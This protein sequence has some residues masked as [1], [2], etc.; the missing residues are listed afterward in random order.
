MSLQPRSLL[1]VGLASAALVLGNSFAVAAGPPSP[2]DPTSAL[3]SE[4]HALRLTV[5]RFMAVA[6]RVQL[7]V[8]RL[9]V[10]EQRS[11]KV[12]AQLEQVRRQLAEA[13]LESK[14]T[15]DEL[16][17]MERNLLTTA[18]ERMGNPRR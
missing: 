18:D 4:V 2:G 16:E 17:D 10:E 13:S 3:L 11:A 9:N 14:K 5:E 7:L 8:A 15:A 6:P 1:A 12:S